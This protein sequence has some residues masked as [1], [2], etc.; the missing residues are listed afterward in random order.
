V[1]KWWRKTHTRDLPEFLNVPWTIGDL[2]VFVALWFGIQILIVLLLRGL[3][4]YVPV[5]AQFLRAA[6][7]PNN[8]SASFV[9]ELIDAV[10]GFGVVWYYLN[11]YKVG[12][13]AVG[14]RKVSIWKSL[15]YLGGILLFF[16][17]VSN[18]LLLLVQVLVP[19]FNANQA[20]TGDQTI[21]SGSHSLAIIALVLLPPIL[22]ETIFRGFLF[23]ALAKRWGM[24]WGAI[25]SSA[26]F[27]I[28]HWQANISLYTFVLGLLLCFMYVRLKSIVPGIFVHMLNNYLAY[29]ALTSK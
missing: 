22:E 20:Q 4:P 18:L 8:V 27:G 16:I 26:I 21:A 2:F 14:W 13:S 17:V 29:I 7:N 28:A 19:G 24:V 6:S 15:A 9:L 12:W 10:A 23:A 11:K 5:V 3:S 1:K 25:I